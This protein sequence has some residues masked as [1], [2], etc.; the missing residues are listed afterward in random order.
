MI[1]FLFGFC[2][3]FRF[4]HVFKL[5][6]F[7]SQLHFALSVV[8]Y[9]AFGREI[10]KY[11]KL[12]EPMRSQ[13]PQDTALLTVLKIKDSKKVLARSCPVF[14]KLDLNLVQVRATGQSLIFH[15]Y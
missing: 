6:S 10:G 7:N 2:F 12:T 3:R 9:H 14:L 13:D 8:G 15:F 4:C 11:C 1:L 5:R